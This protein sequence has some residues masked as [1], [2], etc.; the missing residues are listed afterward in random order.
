MVK[1]TAKVVHSEEIEVCF[2]GKN[3]TNLCGIGLLRKF[4]TRLGVERTLGEYVKLPR[5]PSKYTA[6]R[7]LSS[8]VYAIASDLLELKPFL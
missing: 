3:L 6:E 4:F 1:R 5:G 2:E 7:L 8:L